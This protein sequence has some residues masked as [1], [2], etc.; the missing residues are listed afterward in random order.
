[1]P[2]AA[3]RRCRHGPRRSNRVRFRAQRE[4][5]QAIG[6]ADGV[7]PVLAA[8]QKLVDINLMADIP[9]EFVLGRVENPMQ[10]EG[11]FDHAKVGPEMSAV[12]GEFGDQLVAD[13]F[14]Q[15]MQVAAASVFSRGT[16]HPPYRGIGSYFVNCNLVDSSELIRL[17]ELLAKL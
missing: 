9:D 16:V 13:F 15:L 2:S 4:A 10:S 5:I 6:G 17:F 7:K 3:E 8:G 11:Q 14:R 1:M 12:F